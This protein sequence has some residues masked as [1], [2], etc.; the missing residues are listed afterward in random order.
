LKIEGV[1]ILS[2]YIHITI[3]YFASAKDA[4]GTRMESKEVPEDTS[5]QE[6]LTNVSIVY[7]KIKSIMK[8]I[9]V[10]VNYKVVGLNTILKDGDEIAL[11]PPIS[12]G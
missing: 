8:I 3:L 6:L 1:L 4:T 5:V 11:L 2:L 9:Q 7:P 12:G 10:S